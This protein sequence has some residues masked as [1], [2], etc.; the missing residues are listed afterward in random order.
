MNGPQD[1]GG[2]MGFGPVRPEADEPVFHAGWERR[3][4]AFTVAMG[5]TGS[6]KIDMARSERE[7]QTALAY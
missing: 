2:M 1:M 5:A 6:W 7:S 4:F 3:A